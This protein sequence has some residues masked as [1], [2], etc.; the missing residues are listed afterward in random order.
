MSFPYDLYGRILVNPYDADAWTSSLSHL[1]LLPL[2][3]SA[4]LLKRLLLLFPTSGAAVLTA[5]RAYAK[6]GDASSAEKIL[7]SHLMEAPSPPLFAFYCTFVEDTKLAPAL[8]ELEEARRCAASA[9]APSA[10]PAAVSSPAVAAALQRCASARASVL[11]AYKFSVARVGALWGSE[12]LWR[13]YTAFA[14]SLPT[15]NAFLKGLAMEAQ[16]EALQLAAVMPHCDCEA[17]WASYA[18]FE[19]P[20]GTTNALGEANLAKLA[21]AHALAASVSKERALLWRDICIDALPTAQ[22][23]SEAQVR[24]W[25]EA[26]SYEAGNPLQLEA[27]ALEQRVAG[28]F[29]AALAG[30]LR[31]CPEMWYEYACFLGLQGGAG[32]VAA[33]AAGGGEAAGGGA[34]GAAGGV[35]ALRQGMAALPGCVSLCL[36]AADALEASGRVDEA[37]GVLLAL[38]SELTCLASLGG[39]LR[40]HCTS[41]F[42]EASSTTHAS[43]HPLFTVLDALCE[44]LP[45]AEVYASVGAQLPQSYVAAAAAA[46]A[47]A[48]GSTASAGSGSGDGEASPPA[49]LLRALLLPSEA[50]E[51]EASL[52][53]VFILHQRQ[54]QRLG[55]AAAARAVFSTARRSPH[56]TPAV[57]MASA[58]NEYFCNGRDMGVAR[59]IIEAARKRWPSDFD[60]ILSAVDFLLLHDDVDSGRGFLK[61]A[62]QQAQQGQR[63]EPPSAPPAADGS[64]SAAAKQALSSAQVG[65]LWDR[66]LSLELNLAP[67]GGSLDSIAAAEG[68]ML[69]ASPLLALQPKMCRQAHRWCALG[70]GGYPGTLWD[71]NFYARCSLGPS[72]VPFFLSAAPLGSAPPTTAAS[73]SLSAATE[74]TSVASRGKRGREGS[75]LESDD[76]P[77]A[78]VSAPTALAVVPQAPPPAPPQWARAFLATLPAYSPDLGDCAAGIDQIIAE[79][80]QGAWGAEQG[81]GGPL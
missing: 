68:R 29:K 38:E 43:Q 78:A 42:A 40:S 13:K 19:R 55:G 33:F 28:I 10:A 62:L 81:S 63:G 9:A 70:G 79:L 25:R 22:G 35:E 57:F 17:S 47:A 14:A 76:P 65:L 44:G 34:G 8:A 49:R 36:C 4:P 45:L 61:A 32:G 2:P 1:S 26:I 77:A 11:E 74:G 72:G 46:A 66:L 41:L 54:A 48:A 56:V 7:L 20:G 69:A 30:P 58:R 52:P 73:T 71:R 21:R 64:S 51:A 5:A 59:N 23:S 31:L 24:A 39:A 67:G 3:T 53:Q 75:F 60:F 18:A 15:D 16:R 50:K 12:V 27:G 80:V 37:G 6:H